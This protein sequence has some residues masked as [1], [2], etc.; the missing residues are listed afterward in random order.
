MACYVFRINYNEH[1]KTIRSELLNNKLR[2]GWGAKE[3]SID[4][5]YKSFKQPGVLIGVKKTVVIA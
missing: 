1:Y 5:D 2:Q 4:Q 3:M